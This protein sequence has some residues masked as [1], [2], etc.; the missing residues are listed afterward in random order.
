[1]KVIHL[2]TKVPRI[3]KELPKNPR[4]VKEVPKIQ[5]IFRTLVELIDCDCS[6]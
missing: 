6:L 4:S 1:M 2:L 5:I 3:A